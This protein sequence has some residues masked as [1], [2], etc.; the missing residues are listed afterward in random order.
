MA[1]RLLVG[2]GNPGPEYEGTRHNVGFRFVDRWVGGAGSSWR[3]F[4]GLGVFT[5]RDEVLVAKPTTYMNESGRF[6]RM[7]ASFHNVVASDMLVVYDELSLPLGKI[8]LRRKGSSGGQKGMLSIIQHMGTEELPRLR[9][10]IGPQ[11]EGVDS[12][13]FVLGRFK[14]SEDRDLDAALGLAEDAVRVVVENGLE[15]AMNRFNPDSQA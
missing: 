7:F 14:P 2:L 13:D 9:I 5:K 3:P 1:L 6:V 15:A 8:R 10:G 12:A 11:S 4:K